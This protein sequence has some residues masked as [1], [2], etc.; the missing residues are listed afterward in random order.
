MENNDNNSYEK[1]CVIWYNLH[2]LINVQN[3]HGGVLQFVS[4]TLLKVTLLHGFFFSRF[5]NYANVTES[6]KA[7]RLM[8]LFI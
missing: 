8:K 2:N 1:L 5:L 7:S 6:L 3:T 4:A